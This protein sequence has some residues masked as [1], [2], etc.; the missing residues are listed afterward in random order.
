MA[1]C[2]GI[3]RSLTIPVFA[4][5]AAGLVVAE[6]AE[7]AKVAKLVV[8]GVVLPVE[9]VRPCAML[10]VVVCVAATACVASPL[11]AFS[12]KNER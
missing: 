9:V 12:R 10:E 1:G 3:R 11:V 7:V 2:G 4:D 8:A 6:L 5:S